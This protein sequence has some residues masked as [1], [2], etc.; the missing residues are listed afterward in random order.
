VGYGTL[1]DLGGLMDFGEW[2]DWVTEVDTVE[3]EQWVEW[4][5]WCTSI[6]IQHEQSNSNLNWT[7]T[8][9]AEQ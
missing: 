1:P 7:I 6:A 5:E 4:C 3:L 2:M 9:Q 8:T